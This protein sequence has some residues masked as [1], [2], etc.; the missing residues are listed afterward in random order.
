[1]D[2]RDEYDYLAEYS[3]SEWEAIKE[4]YNIYDP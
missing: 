2:T 3:G 4:N 1:V